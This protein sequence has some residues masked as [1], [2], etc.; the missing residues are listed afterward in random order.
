MLLN[1]QRFPEDLDPS[2]I[3]TQKPPLVILP[4]LFGSIA[5]WRSMARLLSQ[6]RLVYVIDQRNHG[7]SAHADSHTYADMVADLMDFCDHLKLKSIDLAGHSMGGKV[8]MLAAL[9]RPSLVAKLVVLDIAPVTYRHSHAPFLREM[10]N[11]DLATLT[12]RKQADQAL[13]SA[14]PDTATRLFLLQSLAGSPGEYH[15]RLNLPVLYDYMDEII[16]FPQINKSVNTPTL[17]LRGEL[18]TYLGEEQQAKILELFPAATFS[19]IGG[20]GHW[21]HAEQPQ[22]VFDAMDAFL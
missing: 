17:V 4:G 1:Y 18:S 22:A 13:K 9:E 11:V 14:I 8:A 16:G 15:W 6:S 2:E 3:Q 12:S 19:V 7:R 21:L 20:A 5:N 10:L